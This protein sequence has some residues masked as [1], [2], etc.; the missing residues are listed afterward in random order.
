M[1]MKFDQKG[2]PGAD[3]DPFAQLSQSIERSVRKKKA[4]N[5]DD[6]HQ[7]HG[8]NV[9]EQPHDIADPSQSKASAAAAA[10][11]MSHWSDQKSPTAAPIDTLTTADRMRMMDK[12]RVAHDPKKNDKAGEQSKAEE[13]SK[14]QSH[15]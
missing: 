13:P 12:R 6:I 8:D 2:A 4:L 5:D 14:T 9:H 10:V 1:S 15:E 3:K 7:E 11:L